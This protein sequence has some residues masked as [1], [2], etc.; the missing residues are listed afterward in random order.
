MP[1]PAATRIGDG[2]PALVLGERRRAWAGL[3]MTVRRDDI[4]RPT[5]W[6]IQDDHHTVVVHLGGHMRRL[7]TELDGFGGSHGPAQPGEVWT[8]PAGRRYASHAEGTTIQYV[9]LR[10]DPAALGTPA[11]RQIGRASCRERV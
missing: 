8:V 3:V 6:R 11:A 2:V 1:N 7:E 10:L 4:R 5:D 9:V